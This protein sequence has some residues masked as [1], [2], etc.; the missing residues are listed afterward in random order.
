VIRRILRGELVQVLN[1][2]VLVRTWPDNLL[3]ML[4]ELIEWFLFLF[5]YELPIIEARTLRGSES[6][7]FIEEGIFDTF[8]FF[9]WWP[10][11]MKISL[12]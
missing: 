8:S 5:L 1:V 10:L 9:K 11:L 7:W 3:L 12:A 2:F 4:I 6:W